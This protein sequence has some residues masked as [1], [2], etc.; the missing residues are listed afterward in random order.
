MVH[1][2]RKGEEGREKKSKGE[3]GRLR[4]NGNLI[5]VRGE[6]WVEVNDDDKEDV[7]CLA[8]LMHYE[9]VANRGKQCIADARY[10]A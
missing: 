2:F 4:L 9:D 10:D 1:R 3:R 5:S 8:G 7:L 6:E